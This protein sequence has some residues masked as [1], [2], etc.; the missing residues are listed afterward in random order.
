MVEELKAINKYVYN[1]N[2]TQM[3]VPLDFA[4][5]LTYLPLVCNLNLNFGL[6]HS[7]MNY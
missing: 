3:K 1:L 5:I 2:V 4:F 6:K 7:G